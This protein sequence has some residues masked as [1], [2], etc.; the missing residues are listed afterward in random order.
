MIYAINMNALGCREKKRGDD[1]T[2]VDFS[3]VDVLGS[4]PRGIVI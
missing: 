4:V 1:T 2:Y 3:H